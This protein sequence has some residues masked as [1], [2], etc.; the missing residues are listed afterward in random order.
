MHDSLPSRLPIAV[1]VMKIRGFSTMAG[2][3][4]MLMR[5]ISVT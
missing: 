4:K 3:S 5:P 2:G 1:D